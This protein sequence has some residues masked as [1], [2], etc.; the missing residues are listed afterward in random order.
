M[1][2]SQPPFAFISPLVPG[3]PFAQ[4]LNQRE[5]GPQREQKQSQK[6]AKARIGGMQ[7]QGCGRR[8]DDV[9]IAQRWRERRNMQNW[10][11][12]KEGKKARMAAT[13]DDVLASLGTNWQAKYEISFRMFERNSMNGID[14]LEA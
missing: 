11:K 10:P 3:S 4:L 9:K 6:P 7:G 14:R 1:S 2:I 12:Q 5:V 13:I 8:D